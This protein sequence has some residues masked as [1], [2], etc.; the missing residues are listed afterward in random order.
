MHAK[1]NDTEEP[2]LIYHALVVLKNYNIP[3]GK[4]MGNQALSCINTG[5]AKQ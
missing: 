3:V 4:V 2:F 5:N 1:E